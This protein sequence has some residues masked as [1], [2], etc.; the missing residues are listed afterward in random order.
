MTRTAESPS[1]PLPHTPPQAQL[2]HLQDRNS[3][4]YCDINYISQPSIVRVA[5]G[6]FSLPKVI[7]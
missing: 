6:V 2:D 7:S 3:K 4:F 1:G 5:E